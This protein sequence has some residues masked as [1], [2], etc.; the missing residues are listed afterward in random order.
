MAAM[1]KESGLRLHHV[2]LPLEPGARIIVRHSPGWTEFSPAPGLSPDPRGYT[3]D[4]N[5]ERWRAVFVSSSAGPEGAFL[6]L[7][8]EG[9]YP[10]DG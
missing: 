10:Q 8:I 5:G 7:E 6:E 4:L 2:D 3:I 1:S 9:R